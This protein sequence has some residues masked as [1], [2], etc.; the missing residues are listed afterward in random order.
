M[1]EIKG[2]SVSR[3]TGIYTTL[4]RSSGQ[5][6]SSGMGVGV[7]GDSHCPTLSQKLPSPTVCFSRGEVWECCIK[8]PRGVRKNHTQW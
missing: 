4:P 7:I 8:A 1:G 3:Y 6:P 5:I 2:K